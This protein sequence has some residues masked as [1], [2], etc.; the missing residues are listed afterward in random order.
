ME[1]QFV[2]KPAFTV[3]GLLLHTSPMNPQ[4]P[5]LWDQFVPRINEIPH[6]AEPH[7][8]YGL[9]DNFDSRQ[10][11]LDYMAGCCVDRADQLPTGMT[12][13]HILANT[14]AV[15]QATLSDIGETFD[16]I[17]NVWLPATGTRQAAG[18]TFERYGESFNPHDPKL[19][20]FEVYIPV[21]N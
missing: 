8:S 18:P 7:V 19:A 15:F 9:M 11:R 6:M 20:Q 21:V 2:K 10:N 17:Y 4:I 1:P 3:V 13:W 5:G 16:Y 14:Y 12:C